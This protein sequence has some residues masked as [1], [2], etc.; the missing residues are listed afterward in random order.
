MLSRELLNL[1]YLPLYGP[2]GPPR[3]VSSSVECATLAIF[4]SSFSPPPT[5]VMDDA[6]ALGS[7]PVL[8]DLSG[9]LR[10]RTLLDVSARR[11]FACLFI[12]RALER[13]S[14]GDAEVADNQRITTEADLDAFLAVVGVLVD[15]QD[16]ATASI[17]PSSSS[18]TVEDLTEELSLLAS[19]IHLVGRQ[20]EA[21]EDVEEKLLLLSKMRK[22]LAAGGPV[23]VRATFPT[24]VFE[25]SDASIFMFPRSHG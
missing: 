15:R 20:V 8:L 3:S 24:L 10:L 17:S 18:S 1:L 14:S 12:A 13:A 6:G 23:V 21:R 25:V 22:W 4:S 19:A 7:L 16:S 5:V 9:L 2:G 11:R